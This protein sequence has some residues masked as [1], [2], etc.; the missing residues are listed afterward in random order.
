MFYKLLLCV[1]FF[2]LFYRC[3]NKKPQVTPSNVEQAQ[4]ILADQRAQKEKNAA[5]LKCP[6]R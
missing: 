1:F 6:Y 5:K 3:A 4:K 2:F